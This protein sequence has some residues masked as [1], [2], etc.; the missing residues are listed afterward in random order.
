VLAEA[1]RLDAVPVTTPKDAVRLPAVLRAEVRVA[2]VAIAWEDPAA[3]E[4][5]LS[6]LF[7]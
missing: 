5:L 4:A 7:Q 1:A 2:D 3:I 6:L